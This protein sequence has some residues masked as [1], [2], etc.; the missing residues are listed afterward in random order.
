MSGLQRSSVSFRRQ[1]SSGRI[2]D[3]HFINFAKASTAEPNISTKDTELAANRI[4]SPAAADKPMP[5][6][7]VGTETTRG[8]VGTHR[9]SGQSSGVG[10]VV[11][12]VSEQFQHSDLGSHMRG[13]RRRVSHKHRSEAAVTTGGGEQATTAK[14]NND[15]STEQRRRQTRGKAEDAGNTR[16][17]SPEKPKRATA[18]QNPTALESQEIPVQRRVQ[19]VIESLRRQQKGLRRNLMLRRQR[20]QWQKRASGGQAMLDVGLATGGT[21]AK[22]GRSSVERWASGAG[23]RASERRAST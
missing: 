12:V 15:C 6:K 19:A 2:W 20:K 4:E 3:D 16:K 18:D 7:G 13:R 10:R 1:G 11:A 14:G 17:G 23:R 9:T 8:W 5:R 21:E 22:R